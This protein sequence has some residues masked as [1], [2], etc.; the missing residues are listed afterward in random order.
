MFKRL[1]KRDQRDKKTAT[2]RMKQFKDD[3]KHWSDYDFTVIND[4]VEKCYKSI[5]NFINLQKKKKYTFKY[6]R[7][8]IK[9]HINT[10]TN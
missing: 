2:E 1:L 8:F 10:L 9:N 4:Q 6:D 7:K 3:V 5:I